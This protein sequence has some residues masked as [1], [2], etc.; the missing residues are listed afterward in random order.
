M[1]N[2]DTLNQTLLATL[3]THTDAKRFI[4]SM[5]EAIAN[6]FSTKESLEELFSRL[7]SH[8]QKSVLLE[9][10]A[11]AGVTQK[12]AIAVEKLLHG[13][14]DTVARV[15]VLEMTVAVEPSEQGL[16]RIKEWIDTHSFTKVFLEIKVNPRIIGGVR[17]AF[18]GK[19]HDYTV[20][21]T[22]VEKI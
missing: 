8:D 13:I 3:I 16:L 4:E 12:Q 5:D 1:N 22:I 11:T 9:L 20:K 18:N 21:K 6:T 19:Y 2:P 17:I 14:R 10:I 15:P 7:F